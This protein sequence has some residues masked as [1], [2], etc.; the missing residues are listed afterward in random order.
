[1]CSTTPKLHIPREMG[2][3]TWEH[4]SLVICMPLPRKHISIVI[5][6][7]LPG[8]QIS[9][10]IC[11]REMHITRNIIPSSVRFPDPSPGGGPLAPVP[12]SFSCSPVT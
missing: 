10:V 1:M 4:I 11:T 12:A 2:S 7:P 3:P 9:S 8:K 5:C 6:V